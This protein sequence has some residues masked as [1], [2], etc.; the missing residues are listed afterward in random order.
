MFDKLLNNIKSR[1]SLRKSYIAMV[2]MC[3]FLGGAAYFY[4][5]EYF[6]IFNDPAKIRN[7]I[8][9][10]G[11][12]SIFAFLILQIIQ[13]VAF[14]IP[15]EIIQIAGG[16]IFGTFYGS[17]LSLVGITLGSAVIYGISGLFGKPLV[18]KI[19]SE[20]HM[21][22]FERILQL[23]SA[24]YVVFLLYLIPGIPKD[25]FGFI[26]GISEITFRNF[27]LYSTLGRIPAIVVSAYFGSKIDTGKIGMLSFIAIVMLILFLLGM[28]KGD[29]VIKKI[30]KRDKK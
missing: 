24:N 10:Y 30:I 26:C 20:R 23:G 27:I 5:H 9:S 2:L 19:I 8:M 18:K 17:I 28:L 16:Y 7:A 4:F 21:D 12:Y 29:K 11:R 13:V 6:Y 15:G 3:V 22:F 1:V 25:L 14:F